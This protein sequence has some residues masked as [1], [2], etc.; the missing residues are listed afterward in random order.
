MKIRDRIKEFRRV[1][2]NEL[3]PN[4]KNW[5]KHPKEQQEAL[6]GLLSEIGFAGAVLAR[7]T[8]NGLMLID[9][10]LRTETVGGASIPVLILDVN[11]TEADK[12]LAT[13]DPL[14]CM[15]DADSEKLSAILE[16]V[17]TDNKA[18]AAMLSGLSQDYNLDGDEEEP[19]YTRTIEAPVYEPKNEKPS[20]KAIVGLQK[21]DQLIA[22]INA[23]EGI[24]D[25]CK[26]LLR[27]AAT[28]HIVFNYELCAD[29]YAHSPA[30]VQ[31]LMERSALVII[32]MNKAIEN[33]YVQISNSL[34]QIFEE[35]HE[36]E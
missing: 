18:L 13:Y 4:P 36:Q 30:S 19:M 21:Y 35:E 33:G 27:L 12:I 23:A 8:A 3:L 1:P 17:Q 5:R 26:N 32:D 34:S 9:G 6:Q 10:H 7:E 15:A 25:A 31:D 11:E 2:A 14:S 28:R 16:S 20:E 24:D 22:Q 29:Y